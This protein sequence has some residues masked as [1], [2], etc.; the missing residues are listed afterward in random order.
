MTKIFKLSKLEFKNN[1]MLF[2][3]FNIMSALMLIVSCIISS[4]VYLRDVGGVELYDRNS[5]MYVYDMFSPS[6]VSIVLFSTT[7]FAVIYTGVSLMRR[8]SKSDGTVYSI[9]QLPVRMSEHLGATY[10]ISLVYMM[11]NSLISIIILAVYSR[12]LR[13]RMLDIVKDVP[14]FD[15]K[16]PSSAYIFKRFIGGNPFFTTD[17][18]MIFYVLVKWIILISIVMTGIFLIKSAKNLPIYL[19]ALIIVLSF[20]SAN[21]VEFICW[22]TGKLDGEYLYKLI[23]SAIVLIGVNSFLIRRMEC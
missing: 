20:Y 14:I 19:T 5:G 3:G 8:L 6:F 7:I 13:S 10:L 1:W 11:V 16:V 17:S 4:L 2:I 9:M 23:I 22:G 15:S 12:Y 21:I 18:S